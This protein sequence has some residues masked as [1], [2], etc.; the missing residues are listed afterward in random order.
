[1]SSYNLRSKRRRT[2]AVGTD[3]AEGAG[4]E[5]TC[6]SIDKESPRYCEIDTLTDDCLGLVLQWVDWRDRLRAEAVCQRWSR[7]VKER[8]WAMFDRL[9]SS[10]TM[11]SKPGHARGLDRQEMTH[12]LSRCGP[13]IRHLTLHRMWSPPLW[14]EHC[15]VLELCPNVDHLRLQGYQP[16]GFHHEVVPKEMRTRLL[17]LQLEFCI[18]V[19]IGDES[20][21]HYVSENQISQFRIPRA[22]PT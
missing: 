17:S 1:M 4:G 14:A 15:A 11:P 19:W 6:G 5:A 10:V 9:D 13:Y 3:E 16:D 2:A 18:K 22:Y 20:G 12:L 8:G 7:A 21:L